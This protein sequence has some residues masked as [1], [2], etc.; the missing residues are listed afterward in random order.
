MAAI[1]LLTLCSPGDV[2]T[3][4]YTLSD[5]IRSS[6]D[7]PDEK[8]VTDKNFKSRHQTLFRLEGLGVWAG[9]Y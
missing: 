1:M 4:N 3:F 9:D 5:F 6:A 2:T 7:N 8:G